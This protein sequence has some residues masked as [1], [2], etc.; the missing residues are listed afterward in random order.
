MTP[1][2]YPEEAK[3]YGCPLKNGN[4]IGDACMA[5]RWDAVAI[6]RAPARGIA[7]LVPLPEYERSDKGYCGMPSK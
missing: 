6:P 5:W 2:M 4:C 7:A 3:K 1:I